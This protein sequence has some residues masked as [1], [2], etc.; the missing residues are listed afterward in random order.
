MLSARPT[1]RVEAGM[2]AAIYEHL[3]RLPVAFHDRWPA[4]QLMSRAVAD[5]ATIRRFLAFGLVFLFV[6][7]ATF[8]VGVIILLVLSP[9]LGAIV[10]VM[11]VPLVGL[12]FFYETRY[13]VLARRSQDQVGDLA[14]M[15]E[16]SVLGI[17]I[18][19]AFGRSGHLARP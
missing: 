14:T 18:L 7:L 13:Q 19:K 6:N 8:V 9:P 11:A 5:L 17:R 4:G 16:E 1:M 10:A 2:R 15:V 12:C 3:Q